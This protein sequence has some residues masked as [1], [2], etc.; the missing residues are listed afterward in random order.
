MFRS[1]TTV[2]LAVLCLTAPSVFAQ[3]GATPPAQATAGP[4]AP[5]TPPLFFKEDWSGKRAPRD[6]EN[7]HDARCEVA[8]T[9]EY[10]SNPNLELKVYGGGKQRIEHGEW[11][12]SILGQRGHLFTGM[13]GQPVAVAVRD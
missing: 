6:C 11:L 2:L 1:S 12:G 4:I 10:V 8:L 7:L 13:T 5:A 9:Q 3:G